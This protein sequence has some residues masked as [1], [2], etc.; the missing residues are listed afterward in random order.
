LIRGAGGREEHPTVAHFIQLYRV[1]S[2]YNPINRVV[3]G[4]ITSD[5]RVSVLVSLADSLKQYSRDS[6]LKRSEIQQAWE[7]EL[8]TKMKA[9]KLKFHFQRND[10]TSDLLTNKCFVYRLVGYVVKKSH[11]LLACKNCASSLHAG[12]FHPAEALLTETLDKGRANLT[13]PSSPFYYLISQC[14][15]PVVTDALSRGELFGDV[16]LKVIESIRVLNPTRI[17]CEEDEHGPVL[18]SKLVPYYIM[19]RFNFFSQSVKQ[20]MKR[21]TSTKRKLSKLQGS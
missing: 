4:N 19:M 3:R 10:P 6:K 2:I 5:E 1:L 17:G 7:T 16:M 8:R 18:L 21:L 9:S 15:E 12:K 14:V 20:D 13:F 11:K